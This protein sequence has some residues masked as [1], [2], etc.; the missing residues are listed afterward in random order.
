MFTIADI[1]EVMDVIKACRVNS[2]SSRVSTKF[3]GLNVSPLKKSG[4]DVALLSS[5]TGKSPRELDKSDAYDLIYNIK[6]R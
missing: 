3:N 2:D 6:M 4:D 1:E 5:S